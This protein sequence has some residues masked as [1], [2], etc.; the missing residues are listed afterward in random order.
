MESYQG[1]HPLQPSG[2]RC[3]TLTEGSGGSADYS[4]NETLGRA[5]LA[6]AG[7]GIPVFPLKP[8][9]KEPLTRHG[10]KDAT[11][12]HAKITAW[13]NA[14]PRANIGIP[15]G[16]PS[17]IISLDLDVYKAGAMTLE[18]VEA[19]VGPLPE[20]TAR[21]R[22]GRGGLQLYFRYPE[23]EQQLKG[24][25]EDR[26]GK[27]V[28]VKASGGYVVAPP[29][30]TEGRYE[31]L[32]RAP[33]AAPPERLLEALR[34][35]S[36]G[37]RR[38]AGT[39]RRPRSRE[40]VDDTGGPI[41]EGSRNQTMTSIAGELHDGTRDL[42]AL[43]AELLGVN[44]RRCDPPLSEAEVLKIAASIHRREPC[45][46][47]GPAR[48][49]DPEREE[50]VEALEA[51][52]C[53][54]AWPGVGGKTLASFVR[55]LIRKGKRVGTMIP[56]VGLRVQ[57]SVRAAAEEIGCHRNT[58]VNATKRAR[59][60]GILRKDDGFRTG[61]DAGA[62]VLLDPR[63]A[64]DTHPPILPSGSKKAVD[65]SVTTSSRR[66]VADL[67]TKHYRWRGLVGKG[68]EMA[69]C[70]IEAFGLQSAQELAVRLRWA[71]ARDLERRYLGSLVRLGLLVRVDGLYGLPEH[72]EAAQERVKGTPYSTVQRRRWR[73][74]TPE[75][76]L[77]T[78]VV[79]SGG[80]ASEQE[81]E[82]ADRECH[83]RQRAAFRNR[84]GVRPDHHWA[85]VGVDADGFIEDLVP[86]GAEP[87]EGEEA[88]KP[89][90]SPLAAAVRD[91]LERNPHDARQPPGWIGTTLWAFE[92]CPGK[93]TAAF[94]STAVEE[95]GGEAYLRELLGR[96]RTAG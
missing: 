72:Y 95:L 39:R 86:V 84:H 51:S 63:L 24:I 89:E 52:W 56:G 96:A 9:G 94:V 40:G 65:K 74:H 80:L 35:Q 70:L 57:E 93:P 20:K 48:D 68:R 37:R 82:E 30:R 12:D 34:E 71:R 18:E 49:H 60:L 90:V 11:T 83:A 87:E 15:T 77:A 10:F 26:L 43:E 17:D 31:W 13:W 50:L 7:Q 58:I 21:L 5:A 91:Y 4:A 22:T 14:N 46:K 76:R 28:C 23:G 47:R 61:R 62:F 67:T 53:S 36:G 2:K 19:E 41:R 38:D 69:L 32:E 42:A 16:E 8:G 1:G 92:L 78:E 3:R 6:Y 79:E 75:G 81:R 73:T 85:N 45:K 66:P 44:A 64:C 29:S 25:P 33:I 54:R 88:P 27:G 55:H 59:K